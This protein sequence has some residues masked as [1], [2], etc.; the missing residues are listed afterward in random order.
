MYKAL[1]KED[2][3]EDR[4]NSCLY[5]ETPFLIPASVSPQRSLLDPTEAFMGEPTKA[6]ADPNKQEV[7]QASARVAA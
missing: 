6:H 3:R 5:R 4:I 1:S 7:S 2:F